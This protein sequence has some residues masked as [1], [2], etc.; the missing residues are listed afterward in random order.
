MTH[1][2]DIYK[3]KGRETRDGGGQG[4]KKWCVL[5]IQTVTQAGEYNA[6]SGLR[7]RWTGACGMNKDGEY[8]TDEYIDRDGEDGPQRS[9]LVTMS[10]SRGAKVG[11]SPL[12][13]R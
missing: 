13:A 6:I 7:I 8:Q 10:A 3:A 4:V 12:P 5:Y 11:N 1:T 9:T 2:D